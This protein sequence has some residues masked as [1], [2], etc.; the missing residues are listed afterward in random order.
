MAQDF[1][2]SLPYSD[3]DGQFGS[4]RNPEAGAPRYIG[5]K[6]NDVFSKLFRDLNLVEY[7][8]EEG[9]K[10]EPVLYYPIIPT[11]LLNGQKGIAVGHGSDILNRN[12]LDLV[13]AITG[14][15]K[16]NR[17]AEPSLY[18]RGFNGKIEL[19]D[20][21][22]EYKGVY[23][24]VNTTTLKITEIPP[25]KS[26]E[27]FESHLLKLQEK[28]LIKSYE[29]NSSEFPEYTIRM[30]RKILSEM[31]Q[32]DTIDKI[33]NLIEKKTE[34]L[35]VLDENFQIKVFDNIRSLCEHFIQYR[36][37]IYTKRKKV[38]LEQYNHELTFKNNIA[39][40]IAMYIKGDLKIA[41]RPIQDILDDL[42]KHG[43]DKIDDSYEYLIKLPLKRLTKEELV[44]LKN[45]IELTR[46]LIKDLKS[47]TET[48]LYLDDLA[49]LKKD[50]AK[51][52]N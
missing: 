28:N 35:T 24:V 11:V 37:S 49:E 29:D 42:E 21:S 44:K 41:K 18:L 47:K 12:P 15:V 34:N 36:L 30:E 32:K 25:G 48:D 3:R 50:L 22:W 17:W 10:I 7:K 23:E 2:N 5:V 6:I 14:L 31:V 45:E 19:V 8:Y 40:F 38:L 27:D 51:I 9:M 52:M 39:R 20:G 43:F 16:S 33:F 1:K 26:Y 4:L 13:N 46:E